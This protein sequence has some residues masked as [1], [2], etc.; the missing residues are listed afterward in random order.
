MKGLKHRIAS[1]PWGYLVFAILL[2]AAGIL[3]CAFPEESLSN[4]IRVIGILTLL[5]FIVRFVLTLGDRERSFRFAFRVIGTLFALFC[6]GY[7]LIAP[8]ST[9]AYLFTIFGLY[10]IMAGSFKLQTSITLRRYRVPTVWVMLA[11]SLLI[12]AGGFVLLRFEGEEW[13]TLRRSTILLGVSLIVDA[14]ANLLSL[15][16]VPYIEKRRR[17][18][19]ID[20]YKEEEKAAALREEARLAALSERERKKEERR[21]ARAAK[22]AEKR[23]AKEAEKAAMPVDAESDEETGR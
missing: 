14:A 19:A 16:V 5:I 22:K 8:E 13:L 6:G 15:F 9:I 17:N 4:A 7:M 21:A 23:A 12:V 10:L 3:L 2:S 18:A 11:L 20:E 1:L